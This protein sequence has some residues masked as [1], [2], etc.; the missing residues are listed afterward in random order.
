MQE[1]SESFPSGKHHSI[2]WRWV[3]TYYY[4]L[5]QNKHPLISYFR[6]LGCQ[7]FDSQPYFFCLHHGTFINAMFLKQILALA[8]VGLSRIAK[9]HDIPMISLLHFK[10][11]GPKSMVS[12]PTSTIDYG[13]G[14]YTLM[15]EISLLVE[16]SRGP[17][18]PR[19][20][21][22]W[23]IITQHSIKCDTFRI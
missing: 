17:D 8:D 6:Y 3:K 22:L 19:S 4:P 14:L 9:C 18:Y 5:L 13:M 11:N 1:V 20:P 10:L 21:N 12:S 16:H 23:A 7:G 2:T 15:F